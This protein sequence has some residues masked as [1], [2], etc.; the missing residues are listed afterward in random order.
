LRACV[1][2]ASRFGNTEKI[3]RAIESGIREAG[4]QTE[5]F[6]STDATIDSLKDFDLVCVGA[7]T[8]AFTASRPMKDFLGKLK[9]ADFSGKYGFVFDTKV[10][11]RLSGA[12]GK[13]IEK[14]LMNLGLRVVAPRESAIVSTSRDRTGITCA[15]LKGGEEQRFEQIGKQIG[16]IVLASP[17]PVPAR[18]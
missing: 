5:C 11:S 7:P 15:T 9:G 3:A 6:N 16:A 2:F 18:V 4:I 14:E 13:S 17:K 10:E 12:A 1:I 8:E